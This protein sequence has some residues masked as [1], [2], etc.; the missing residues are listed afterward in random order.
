MD[1]SGLTVVH[2]PG[3]ILAKKGQKQV[4]KITSG[5]RGK[6]ITVVCCFNAAGT[7][8]PPMMIYPRKRMAPTLMNGAPAGS[9]AKCSRNEWMDQDLFLDWLRHFRDFVQPTREKPCLLLLDDH[10]S[11]KTLE[12]ISFARDNH[13][14]MLVL[15]P[16]TTHRLQPLDCT[17][18]GPLKTK[19][20]QEADILC[21]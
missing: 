3:H 14:S 6:T 16:H 2:K 18:F 4:G 10:N 5:Q 11:H 15:P 1:E 12:A 21:R 17:F 7:Y 19:F 8:V 20:H 13:I 9:L